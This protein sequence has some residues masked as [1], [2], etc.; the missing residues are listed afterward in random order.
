[1]ANFDL[2]AEPRSVLG[3][4]VR[5]LRRQGIVPA[6]VYGH[7]AST[8]IQVAA[9]DLEHTIRRAGRTQ[10]ISLAIDGETTTVLLKE[11]QR[12]PFRDDLLHADFYRVAMTERLRVDIPV[13]LSGDAPAVRLHGGTLLQSATALTVECLPGDLPDSIEVDVSGLDAIDASI[14]VRDLQAPTNGSFITD[15]G[16]LVVKVLAPT[17]EE[18]VE[19]AAEAP[20]APAAAGEGGEE[21]R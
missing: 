9:R 3:K 10:L 20:A 8:A 16:E 12:H 15:G 21:A 14:Y 11:W 6:N 7:D 5:F 13:R 18:V 4:K 2:R 1:M 17:V 19:P